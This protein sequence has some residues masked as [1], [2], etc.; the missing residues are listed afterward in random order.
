MEYV[1]CA[2]SQSI[3]DR[4]LSFLNPKNLKGFA[5]FLKRKFFKE[6]NKTK[7]PVQPKYF[8]FVGRTFDLFVEKLD[9]SSG[10][11]AEENHTGP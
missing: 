11:D 1:F 9:W 8:S 10:P 4:I 7:D 2:R 6:A 5:R 3:L